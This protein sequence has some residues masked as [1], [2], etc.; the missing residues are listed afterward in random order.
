MIY[1]S[2]LLH[3]KVLVLQSVCLLQTYVNWTIGGYAFPNGTLINENV[4]LK[5]RNASFMTN[6]YDI[7]NN[8]IFF[9]SILKKDIARS[10]KVN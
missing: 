10:A 3:V 2:M 4:I 8:L 6:I 5:L 7:K 9:A 1:Y